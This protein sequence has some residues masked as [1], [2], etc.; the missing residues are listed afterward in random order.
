M[1]LLDVLATQSIKR[2]EEGG[3]EGVMCSCLR[4]C[5]GLI[6]LMKMTRCLGVCLCVLE[7]LMPIEGTVG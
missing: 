3:E 1:V 7:A 4:F 2:R 5:V 6:L